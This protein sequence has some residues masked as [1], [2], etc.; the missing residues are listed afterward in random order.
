MSG[1]IR[2]PLTVREA[3][4]N[5][6]GRPIN[7]IVVTNGS[8]SV[9]GTTA[10]ISTGGG[11]GG[12]GTV[13]SITPAA[14]SGT[15]TAITTSGSF[16]FTGGTNVTT[17]VTG[18]VVTINSTDQYAGTVTSVGTSQAFITITDPTTTPSISIGN[19]SGAATGVLTASDWT[20][21]DGKQDAITLTTT[22]TSGAATLVAGALNIPEYA[23]GSGTVT[24]VTSTDSFVSVATDSTTPVITIGSASTSLTGVLTSTDWNTFDG[25]QAAITL[26]TT[27]TSGAATLVAGALNIPEYATGGGGTIGGTATA[28]QVSYGDTTAD[29]ITSSANLTFDGTY[30]SPNLVKLA[31]GSNVGSFPYALGFASDD[32][33]GLYRSAANELTFSAGGTQVITLGGFTKRLLLGAHTGTTA[34]SLSTYGAQ[35]IVISTNQS[36]N[37]GTITITDGVNENIDILPNGT[38]KVKLGTLPFKADQSVGVGQDNYVLTYDNASDSISLEVG[39]GS[40]TIGGSIASTQVAR[41][42]VTANEIEGDNGLLFDGTSFTINTLTASDPV[43]NMS[44]SSKSVSLE[45]N[46]SQK[47]TVKGSSDSF[48]F[49]ASSATGGITFPDGSTQNS[50]STSITLTTTG[51]SGAATLVGTTLNIPE[52]VASSTSPGGSDGELQYNN[53]GTFGGLNY[54]KRETSGGYEGL[55]LGSA[56]PGLITTQGAYDLKL[57]TNTGVNSGNITISDGIDGTIAILPNGAGYVNLDGL[58]WP[59]SD[60]VNGQV[61]TTDGAASLTWETPSGG[62]GGSLADLYASD[63]T[64]YQTGYDQ[65]AVSNMAPYTPSAKTSNIVAP[66]TSTTFMPFIAPKSGDVDE[67]IIYIATL[68][69]S[70]MSGY[71]AIYDTSNGMPDNLL[72]YATY[73]MNSSTGEISQTVFSSTITLVAGNKYYYSW[74]DNDGTFNARTYRTQCIELDN[75]NP[76]HMTSITNQ[77]DAQNVRVLYVGGLQTNPPAASAPAANYNSSS[78][79][80]IPKL[81]MVIS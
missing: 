69:G 32:D 44:S 26:T 72:G 16:T 23:G 58:R 36:V 54:V 71:A 34:T 24:S 51:T 20:D 14:D 67:L 31:D 11:G 18:T 37:S 56:A 28:T 9:S 45:V 65:W 68:Q 21:F 81:N 4:G 27:G 3:D 35:D 15:G 13:T 74:A 41:G 42:A 8:L 19:A 63:E 80:G 64:Q 40:G 17:A 39:S 70:A 43:L 48:I 52:Y 61:L 5:P 60:G 29:E 25:K 59:T 62:S 78:G 7:T 57:D 47:L 49:D 75:D 33:T 10:T 76:G 38:G 66:T 55:S 50:A 79:S 53:S 22:G 30:L 12:S 73:D 1:P 6:T 2:P 77:I 46:T